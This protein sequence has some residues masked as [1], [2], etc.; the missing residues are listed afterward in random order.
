MARRRESRR[1]EAA[2]FTTAARHDPSRDGPHRAMSGSP[3]LTARP[4]GARGA[5]GS[6]G[7]RG[8]GLGRG[9]AVRPGAAGPANRGLFRWLPLERCWLLE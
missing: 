5:A 2:A 3:R 4:G 1:D 7:A 8:G 9:S 6:R